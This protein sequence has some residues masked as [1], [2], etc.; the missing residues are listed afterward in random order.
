MYTLSP[1]FQPRYWQTDGCN[2]TIR[3]LYVENYS[4]AVLCRPTGAGKTFEA[5]MIIQ[6]F[7]AANPAK[8]VLT[9]F[10]RD[11]LVE[12][13]RN[14]IRTAII[15]T[16]G[17]ELI[18]TVIDANAKKIRPSRVYVAMVRTVMNRIKKANSLR[19]SHGIASLYDNIGLVIIDE[20]HRGEHVAF[21]NQ[22]KER[23]IKIVGFTATP[24][25]AT[26]KL[27]LKSR[28]QTIVT[29]KQKRIGVPQYGNIITGPQISELQA[30]H[31]KNQRE[32]LVDCIPLIPDDGLDASDKKTIV[33][34][35]KIDLA[36]EGRILKK[37]KFIKAVLREAEKF[38]G[39][40][41]GCYNSS[42][43]HSLAMTAAF[44]ADGYNARHLDGDN[45]PGDEKS[46]MYDPEWRIDADGKWNDYESYRKWFW[47]WWEHSPGAVGNFGGDLA[48]TGIDIPS[49]Q[50]CILNRYVNSWPLMMQIA[51]RFS[52][53]FQGKEYFIFVD[54]HNSTA[55]LGDWDADRDLAEIFW[56]PGKP[57]NGIAPTK[58]CPQC[59]GIN[60]A[61]ARICTQNK[62]LPFCPFCGAANANED[63][64]CE[65]IIDDT[66]FL[67]C[68]QPLMVSCG[69]VFPVKL[70]EEPDFVAFKLKK[71]KIDQ[72]I[73]VKL[74][75]LFESK[76]MTPFEALKSETQ[77]LVQ[78]WHDVN[79]GGMDMELFLQLWEIGKEI[80]KK[81]KA[82]QNQNPD[83]TKH[84]GVWRG[85]NEK[86]KEY[87]AQRARKLY[88]DFKVELLTDKL[89]TV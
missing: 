15:D 81:W 5:A 25:S 46:E 20:C 77:K 40:Q 71:E 38:R 19:D 8:S 85:M 79:S 80:G 47:Q 16:N 17:N 3:T 2:A 60:H 65:N 86:I 27:P 30:W 13:M 51:G 83:K 4:T 70:V 33:A 28:Y 22:M 39:Q 24:K 7:L 23:G 84:I 10:H 74:L 52:R 54:M 18:A 34:S 73:L 36:H 78:D 67:P 89:Q 58:F 6:R 63:T 1:N 31:K 29:Y 32:G 50:V 45:W 9:V 41:I 44:G 43:E 37:P 55:L 12:G 21:E 64:S 57:G 11:K 87:M 48:T 66:L 42:I 72:N 62:C 56:N 49:L 26:K 59:K 69:Y 35:G 76:S 75:D 53:T 14:S 82:I 68:S 88:P 61:A